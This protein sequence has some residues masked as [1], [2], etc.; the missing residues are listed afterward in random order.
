MASERFQFHYVRTAPGSISGPS[1]VQQTED[2]I[3]DL[4]DYAYRNGDAAEAIRIAG[5]ANQNPKQRLEYCAERSGNGQ[6]SAFDGSDGRSEFEC[7]RIRLYAG[8]ANRRER[9]R[10]RATGC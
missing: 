9:S 2:A 10:Y 7:C 6:F 3:N 8:R 5:L 4:G 1:F